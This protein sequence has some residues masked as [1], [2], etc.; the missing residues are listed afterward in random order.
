M[1]SHAVEMIIAGFI[2][3]VIGMSLSGTIAST[4]T[5]ANSSYW[6]DPTNVSLGTRYQNASTINSL[7]PMIFE[8]G[9]LVAGVVLMI[10]GGLKLSGR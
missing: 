5:S 6:I 9:L 7:L 8:I 1:N 3:M 10:F 2:V 4:A